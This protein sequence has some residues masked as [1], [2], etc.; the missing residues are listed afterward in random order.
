VDVK[1][2]LSLRFNWSDLLDENLEPW[3]GQVARSRGAYLDGRDLVG[4]ASLT[5]VFSSSRTVNE[6]R[7]QVANC[8]QELISL[9]PTCGVCDEIGEGGPAV[10]IGSIKVRRHPFTP[11]PRE[12]RR[13]QIVDA[14]SHDSGRHLLKQKEGFPRMTEPPDDWPADNNNVA[15]RLG[16]SWTPSAGGGTSF[17]GSYGI[18]YDHHPRVI[19]GGPFVLSGTTDRSRVLTVV[20]PT[21]VAAAWNAPGRRLPEPKTYGSQV[22]TIDPRL[23]RHRL[24]TSPLA[25]SALCREE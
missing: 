12:N 7:L 20:D 23:R 14:F 10:D 9:D 15:P 1:H 6:L 22:I 16:V 24:I 2:Q 18:F 4:A 8:D 19:W 21:A 17:S 3:G 11:Q 25:S 13:Y 5:S